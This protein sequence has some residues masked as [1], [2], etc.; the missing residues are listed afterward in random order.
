M[1]WIPTCAGWLSPLIIQLL[2]S[3]SM[4]SQ[5]WCMAEAHHLHVRLPLF[6]LALITKYHWQ[7]HFG[8]IAQLG[9]W[10]QR[11]ISV[12]ANLSMTI[13]APLERSIHCAAAHKKAG[14]KAPQTTELRKM[15]WKL[16]PSSPGQKQ[17]DLG[18]GSRYEVFFF[19]FFF[20][21]ESQIFHRLFVYPVQGSP[22]YYSNRKW[23]LNSLRN[24]Q[25]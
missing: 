22:S 7:P 1:P 17:A 10:I 20:Q 13:N 15:Q 14:E 18:Q 25:I 21:V 23:P 8:I 2:C 6:L 5:A 12:T 9:A 24:S 16:F 3:V 4:A 11:D 19:F